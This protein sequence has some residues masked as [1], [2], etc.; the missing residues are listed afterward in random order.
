MQFV[1]SLESG[2]RLDL[3]RVIRRKSITVFSTMLTT[4]WLGNHGYRDLGA[5]SLICWFFSSPSSVM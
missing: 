2:F 1:P 3:R 5:V 4:K